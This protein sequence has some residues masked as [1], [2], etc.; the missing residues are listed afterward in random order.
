MNREPLVIS[1][2]VVALTQGVLTAVV[3]M[4][5]WNLTAEQAAAWMG[6]ISLG[7]TFLVVVLT[8]GQVT[9]VADPRIEGMGDYA[10]PV[11]WDQAP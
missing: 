10:A 2:S 1:G 6:V 9:P 8:R 3:L 5:W 7:G 11:D 4:G